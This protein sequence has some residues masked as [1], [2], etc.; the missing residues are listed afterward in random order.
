MPDTARRCGAIR[1]PTASGDQARKSAEF[2]QLKREFAIAAA[3]TAP[4]LLQMVPMLAGGGLFGAAHTDLLPRWLQL[5]LATPVQFWIGR[6]FYVGAWNALRGGGAN[7]DVLVVLG[8][9]MAYA[10]SAVVT[11]LGLHGQHVYFEAGAAVITLVLLGKLLEARAKAGTSAALEG[12][13]RLQPK[14]ARVVRDGVVSDVPLSAVV[15]GD[16][17]VVRAG[18]S[19]PVDGIVRDGT[20]AVDESML[21]GESHAVTKAAGA[22]VFAGTLNQDGLITCEA[23]GVGSNT[24]L[25]G[26]VRLVA[27]AQGSK[28]PIQRLADRVSGIF[29]PVVV[30]VAVVTFGATWWWVGD[31]TQALVHAVAVLVIACPCALGLA[32]PTAIMVGTGRGAQAGI[33]IRNAAALEQAGRLQTL[34]V[35]KTGTLTEGRPSVTDVV[36]LG[37]ATR[38]DVLRIAASL[39]QG[40]THPLAQAVL[41]AARSEGI[42][43]VAIDGFAS[44]PGKGVTARIGADKDASVLGSL[45]FIAESGAAVDPA[46]TAAL[47][48][49]GK[50]IV[51]LARDGRALGVIALADALRPTSAGAVRRLQAAGIAVVMMTGDNAETAAAVARE[52]G[53]AEFRA[54]VLPAAKADAVRALKAKGVV[55]GMVGDG[56][57]DAPALAAADVSFAMGAGADIAVEAA[58]VTLIRSDLDG[59]VDAILLSRATLAKIRQNLFFAFAY[60]VLGI[61]LAAMGMLNPVIAGAAMAASSVSVVSN[62]LLLKRWRPGKSTS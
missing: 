8:T 12:L 19:I 27:E 6:R 34:I 55:T 7:M 24:L 36:P 41:A 54:G 14:T 26:I 1:K 42:E 57:N 59:I 4:L 22:R 25:A 18:E 45:D 60:N 30:A 15:A 13:L 58:D 3:L 40:S 28:A 56:I 39:E 2:A 53:I 37:G 61:P 29:V 50:T 20:S 52:A 46:A 5:V 17:F 48:R 62:A 32:T 35:D 31:L 11:L 38:E 21:T 10:F 47:A 44:S 16:R 43:P 9:T 49:Q 23:T 33:L 51:G